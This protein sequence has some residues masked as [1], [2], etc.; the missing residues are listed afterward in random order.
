[1]KLEERKYLET[2]SKKTGKKISELKEILKRAKEQAERL[3]QKDNE[4]VIKGLFN[5]YLRRTIWSEMSG[6]TRREPVIFKGFILGCG[7]LRDTL[8]F[9]RIK[10]IKAYNEDPEQAKLL[11]L[12]DEQGNPLDPRETIKDRRGNVIENPNFHKPLI[13]HNY[14]RDVYGIAM[15]EGDDKPKLFKATLWRGFATKFTYKPFV[16]IEFKALVNSESP[17]YNLTF[18]RAKDSKIREIEEKIDIME[19]IKTSLKDRTYELEE[20]ERVVDDYKNAIDKEILIEGTVDFIDS[21]VNPKTGTR[22]VLITDADKG[23]LDV[24]RVSVPKDFPLAFRE[25]SRVLVFGVPRK[26]RRSEEDDY[27]IY[28]NGISIYPIPGETVETEI[29][30][31]AETTPEEDEE[32][33]WNLWEE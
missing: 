22:T 7:P 13:G 17:Y 20:L 23:F 11:G 14:V 30:Y 3:G 15:K 31:K 32:E 10:A 27:R 16:P 26:W 1:M 19:W 6:R 33:G 28:M 2:I 29:V 12:V 18:S 24:I 9:L 8:E 4:R 25:Y 21:E 5:K